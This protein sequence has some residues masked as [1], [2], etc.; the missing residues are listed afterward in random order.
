MNGLFVTFDALDGVGKTT[1][2][3][4]LANR[5]ARIGMD[6]PGRELRALSPAVLAG[7]GLNE[8]ARCL[9]YASS[10]LAQGERARAAADGGGL[11]LMDRYWE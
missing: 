11:V 6:T 3:K 10:V 1:L 2:V 9:F 8:T 7:I 4:G 5:V